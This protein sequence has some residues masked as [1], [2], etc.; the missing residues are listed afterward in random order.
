ML[1][2]NL[3]MTLLIVLLSA[4]FASHVFAATSAPEPTIYSLQSEMSVVGIVDRSTFALYDVDAARLC[5]VGVDDRVLAVART[6]NDDYYR[7]YSSSASCEGVVWIRSDAAITWESPSDLAGL[8]IL[9]VPASSSYLE[10]LPMYESVCAAALDDDAPIVN[11]TPD[12]LSTLFVAGGWSFIPSEFVAE[13]ETSLDVVVCLVGREIEVET[14]PIPNGEETI[15]IPRIQE[16]LRVSMVSY[17]SGDV[18][19]TQD[20]EGTT[21]P[22][23]PIDGAT[24]VAIHGSPPERDVWGAWVVATMIGSEAEVPSFRT[25]SAAQ[26]LN[27]RAEANTNSSVLGRLSA[28]TPVNLIGRTEDG[29]WLVALLPDMSKA[30]LF[31]ELLN[32]A[33]QIDVDDLPVYSGSAENVPIPVR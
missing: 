14:C 13:S 28:E 25:I 24:P 29:D 20:F 3:Y 21:P 10:E 2:R 7:V 33:V 19:A 16:N 9:V 22:S 27:A 32:V 30:W 1:R 26:T 15:N 31:A 17:G 4:I 11:A 18:I 23:C 12:E 8:P 6:E 5:N